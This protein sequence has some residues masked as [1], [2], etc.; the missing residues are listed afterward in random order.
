MTEEGEPS[1]IF[2]GIFLAWSGCEVK[3]DKTLCNLLLTSRKED[4][5]W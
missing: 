2:L 1:E 4:S 5:A 3:K